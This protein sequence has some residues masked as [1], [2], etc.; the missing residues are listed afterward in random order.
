MRLPILYFILFLLLT[1]N[2]FG[3]TIHG[4]VYDTKGEKLGYSNI[5]VKGTSNGTS[6][7]GDGQYHLDLASGT[8]DIVFQHLGYKQQIQTINLQKDMEIDVK[9]EETQY[10]IRDVVV[11]GNKDAAIEVIKKAIEKRKYFLS[12]VENYQCDAYVKGMQ[13]I[14]EAPD[15]ILGRKINRTGILTGP[16]NSGILYL[17]ES[18]SKLYYKKPNKFHEVILSSKVSGKSNGFTFNAAQDFYFNFYERSITIPFIAQRPFISPLSENAF[19]YYNYKMLGAFKE[20][21]YLVNKILVTPKRKADPCFTGVLSIIEDNWN[22]HSLELYLTKENGIQYI[23]TLKVTQYFIPVKDNIW[24]PSQQRYDAKASFLG[25]KGDGYYLG[26]FKNY[27]VNNGFA[28]MNAIAKTDSTKNKLIKKTEKQKQKAAAKAEKKAE[29]QIFTPEVVKI[30]NGANKRDTI[31]WDSIRPVPLTAIETQDYELKDSIQVIRDSKKFQDSTDKKNNATGV[32]SIILGYVFKK[33]YKKIEIDFPSLLSI[34]NFNTVEGANLQFH[35]VIRKQFNTQRRISFDPVIRYGFSDKQINAKGTL[36]Y[37]NSEIH[38]EY[39][40]ISG[41]RYV[42]QIDASEPQTE[43][44]NTFQSLVFK[45]NFMK[46]YEQYFARAL[47][48]RELFNGFQGTLAVNYFQRSPLDNTNTFSFFSTV[49]NAYTPNG[50][51]IPAVADSNISR[52]NSIRIDLNFHIV[53]GQQYITR[54][55]MRFRTGS[56]YPELYITY[57]EAVP[58]KGVSDQNFIML[59]AQLKG[60]IPL[61]ILGTTFY[62]FGGGGFPLAKAIDYPD[63]KSF[64]GNFLNLGGTDLLGFYLIQYYRNT[65]DQ[66]FAEAHI[67]HHFG[68][69]LFNKIPG[70]RKLKLDEVVGFHFLYTPVRGAYYQVNAGLANILK[71]IRVDFVAGFDDNLIH[72]FGGRVACVLDFRR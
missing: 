54:P 45:N 56:K 40:S 34:V 66:Y 55:D 6:A 26:I 57:R 29:K 65:T 41:G 72:Q 36:S 30:E 52:H 16:N 9:L 61:K 50:V 14:L 10:Q 53:F 49:K 15:K 7:N 42:G 51:E 28:N 11:N 31:Y 3:F 46:F 1:V 71:I 62:R 17:S 12:V 21:D 38:N 22:I 35:F 63:Y 20:G 48:S 18:Q 33:Q 32:S 19:F 5:Y 70:I 59:E 47:Y 64:S 37:N 39:I 23:D 44:G 43:L 8:Y 68:G 4:T 69:F 25:V 58:I 13:R 2:G 27:I 67:E 60:D 24:L